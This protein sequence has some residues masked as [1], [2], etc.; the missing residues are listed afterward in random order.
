ERMQQIGIECLYAP[1]VP[2]LRAHLA[3]RGH[4]YD[5]VIMFHAEVARRHFDAIDLHCP[6]ARVVFHTSD[7]HHLR[8]ER[9][10]ELER[11]DALRVKA[12]RTKSLELSTIRRADA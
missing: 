4:E 8:E 3:E 10:A 5:L 11:S 1:F 9:H 6:Q 7:L 12:A 2:T